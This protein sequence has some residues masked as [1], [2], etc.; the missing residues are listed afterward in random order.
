MVPGKPCLVTQYGNLPN[1]GL[2]CGERLALFRHY[3]QQEQIRV[4][5]YCVTKDLHAVVVPQSED[6]MAL[7]FQ[8]L[9]EGHRN[10]C[11]PVEAD[12]LF[13]TIRCVERIPVHLGLVNRADDY[14]WSSAAAHVWSVDMRQM[15]DM[16][17]F[18]TSAEGL[19]WREYLG[20]RGVEEPLSL[21]ATA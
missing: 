3:T 9:R 20:P 1:K 21:R 10:S 8:V 12:H 4:L 11:R 16:T 2:P 14:D 19:N 6:A 7:L 17:W 15:L 18:W 13:E 5:A